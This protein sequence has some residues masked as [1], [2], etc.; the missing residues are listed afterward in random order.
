MSDLFMN[1]LCGGDKN[2]CKTF[3]FLILSGKMTVEELETEG[4]AEKA[5]AIELKVQRNAEFE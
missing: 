3:C 1:H 2:N 5:A 4:H